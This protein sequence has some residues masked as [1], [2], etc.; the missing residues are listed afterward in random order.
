MRLLGSRA[1]ALLAT[2]LGV[3]A[4]ASAPPP[5]ALLD[6]RVMQGLAV[7]PGAP[8]TSRVEVVLDVTPSMQAREGRYGTRADVARAAA[9]QLLRA[10]PPE[11]PAT[12][13]AFGASGP[14]CEAT[15]IRLG[16]EVG[17]A[18]VL[19]LH[20]DALAPVA[21]ASLSQTLGS[22]TSEIVAAGAAERTR[23][24]LISDLSD[25]CGSD[26]C[27]A[28]A[29][30]VGT[31][32]TLDLVVIGDADVPACVADLTAPRSVPGVVARATDT[33]PFS[34]R[35]RA[36]PDGPVRAEASGVAGGAPIALA[37]GA[38]VVDVP[39]SP[40]LS[41]PL[42]LEAGQVT[43]MRVIDFPAATPPL[44]D[45]QIGLAPAGGG[46][47]SVQAA[48]P[49]P[50]AP[51]DVAAPAQIAPQPAA[52]PPP[53]G[54][55][56]PPA[57]APETPAAPEPPIAPDVTLPDVAAPGPAP[58]DVPRLAPQADPPAPDAGAP[59]VPETGEPAEA[60]AT[61]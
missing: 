45:W 19:A 28:A 12:L 3:G 29:A 27:A 44:R 43:Q 40:P 52:P 35:V 58:A 4:C 7:A 39:L 36:A 32:A 48:A 31:G 55:D 26:L 33:E 50:D 24:V 38:A 34:F 8:S 59:P 11:A 16:P 37:P 9:A 10:L 2:L 56:A 18:S 13:V 54:L 23:V 53:A 20:T 5:E 17:Y 47:P 22:V 1:G 46:E 42:V 15:P 41:V 57:P 14:E 25:E 49:P 60:P 21:E 6:V 51:P 30:L 61:P